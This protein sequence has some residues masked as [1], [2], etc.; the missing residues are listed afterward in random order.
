[1]DGLLD[2][3]PFGRLTAMAIIAWRR[4]SKVRAVRQDR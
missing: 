4:S 2:Y 3:D 1:M